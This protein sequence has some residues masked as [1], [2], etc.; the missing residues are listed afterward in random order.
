M[1][2]PVSPPRHF[3]LRFLGALLISWLSLGG[4]TWWVC[5]T[6][7]VPSGQDEKEEKEDPKKPKRKPP[8][9]EDDPSEGKPRPGKRSPSRDTKLAVEAEQAKF[10]AAREM[11]LELAVPFDRVHL[12]SGASTRVEPVPEYA[13]KG[14]VPAKRWTFRPLPTEKNPKEFGATSSDITGIDPYERIALTMVT[15]FLARTVAVTGDSPRERA[16]ERFAR[17]QE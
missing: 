10:P 16:L 6:P 7:A 11:F 17:L 2:E 3:A 5:A 1:V 8:K 12:P 4:A 9:V 13:V 14:K 15:D